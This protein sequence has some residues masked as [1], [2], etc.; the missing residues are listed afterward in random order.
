MLNRLIIYFL[1]G[2]LLLEGFF[3]LKAK[4]ESWPTEQITKLKT[5][6][7]AVKVPVEG[8]V[9]IKWKT[10]PVP[11][12][13]PPEEIINLVLDVAEEYDIEEGKAVHGLIKFCA[14][15]LDKELACDWFE[16][17]PGQPVEK[18]APEIKIE[19]RFKEILNFVP[20]KSLIEAFISVGYDGKA[21]AEAGGAYY[22]KRGWYGFRGSYKYYE[23][24]ERAVN[25]ALV[26]RF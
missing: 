22:P 5:K 19:T 6:P 25:A 14:Y 4:F 9:I 12:P 17:V 16:Y 1:I 20:R 11:I 10:K 23:D 3:Y 24:S 2:L 21:Y 26:L 13:C 15:D 7:I 8:D 18:L